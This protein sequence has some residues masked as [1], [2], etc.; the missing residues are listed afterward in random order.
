M[1]LTSAASSQSLDAN[2]QEIFGQWSQAYGVIPVVSY[3][4][5]EVGLW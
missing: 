3:A 5:P 1:P 4:G 2:I